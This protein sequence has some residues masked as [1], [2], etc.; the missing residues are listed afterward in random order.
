MSKR[1]YY[2]DLS[3]QVWTEP[4][5]PSSGY[6]YSVIQSHSDRPGAKVE[7]LAFGEVDELEEAGTEIREA[8][9][10]TLE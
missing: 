9:D 8:I 5:D 6:Y 4:D 2:Y 7:L 10:L 1:K 3:V